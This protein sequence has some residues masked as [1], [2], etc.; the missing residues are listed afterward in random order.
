MRVYRGMIVWVHK[1]MNG[2]QT[3]STSVRRKD[4]VADRGMDGW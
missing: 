1:E 4:S 2:W 3:G